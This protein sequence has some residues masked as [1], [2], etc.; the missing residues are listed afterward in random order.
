MSAL[1]FCLLLA[2][3]GPPPTPRLPAQVTWV[4]NSF[5]G[6]T[7]WMQMALSGLCVA[8]DGSCYTNTYWEEGGAN[9]S[10]YRD[11]ARVAVAEH[12][13]GWGYEGGDCVAVNNAYLYIAQ[14]V[15]CEGGGLQDAGTWPAKGH[16]WYGVSRRQR[17]NPKSGAP[18]EGGKGGAGDTI[19]RS[20]LLVNET[21]DGHPEPLSG[22]LATETELYISDKS[23]G[24][25]AVY[26]AE[27]MTHVRDIS[28]DQPGPLAADSAGRLWVLQ[29]TQ[30]ACLRAFSPG[31]QPLA[32][33]SFDTAARPTALCARGDSL[34][35]ADAGPRQQIRVIGHLGAQPEETGSIGAAGGILAEPAGTVRPGYLCAPTGVGVDAAGN[36]YVSSG[37][38][39]HGVTLQSYDPA[40]RLRWQ[41]DGLT[42]VDLVGTD[43]SADFVLYSAC[44]RFEMD[45]RRPD[46]WQWSHT[47]FTLN[48]LR[49]PDDARANGF[50]AVAWVRRIDGQRLLYLFDQD[51]NALAIYRFD[52]KQGET[53]IPCGLIA[54]RKIDWLGKWPPNQPAAPSYAW[55]DANGDGAMQAAEYTAFTDGRLAWGWAWCVDSRGTIWFAPE[56]GGITRLPLAGLDGH[57]SPRYDFAKIQSSPSPDEFTKVL[58]LRYD[59][60]TDTMTM[61]GCTKTDS[62]C[63]WK[64]MGSRVVRYE[65]W[66]TTERRVAWQANLPR[67]D[68]KP[69]DIVFEPLSFEVEIGRAHV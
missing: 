27:A 6:G 2:P 52:S 1:L 10:V 7:A 54:T 59:P 53:A 55:Y 61:A 9:V 36:L 45:W 56:A 29:S 28:V 17:A 34:L 21:T 20:F 57:G 15:N 30:P 38:F 25:I 3:T 31:G 64:C 22:L 40:G 13:H 60:A 18:F 48:P 47:A 63:H 37:Y 33:L 43:P 65:R 46:G 68:G 39:G 32:T 66:S 58:R 24:R 26:D 12:T 42:F 41:L 16:L 49:Y 44:H 4:A 8:A 23:H 14:G 67:Q 51:S 5:A 35:V 11:G 62:N 50:G 69:G 19:A